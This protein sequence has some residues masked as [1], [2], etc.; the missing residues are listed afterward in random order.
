M[1][2]AVSRGT[3]AIGGAL[4]M[5]HRWIRDRLWKEVVDNP[6][7]GY[8]TVRLLTSAAAPRLELPM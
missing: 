5:S 8:E 6:I 1:I 2:Q 7:D 4:S 3:D